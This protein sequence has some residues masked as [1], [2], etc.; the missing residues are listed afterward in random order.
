MI[1]T[2]QG[3][4]KFISSIVIAIIVIVN[5]NDQRQYRLFLGDMNQSMPN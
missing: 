5:S 2:A 4:P 3:Q 1:L